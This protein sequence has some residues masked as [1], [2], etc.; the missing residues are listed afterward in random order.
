M[1][2]GDSVSSPPYYQGLWGLPLLKVCQK[3]NLPWQ[4]ATQM[5]SP[6]PGAANNCPFLKDSRTSLAAGRSQY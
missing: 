4:Q 2:W 5:L 6:P 3:T 1:T